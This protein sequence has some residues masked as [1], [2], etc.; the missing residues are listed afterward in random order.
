MYFSEK[1]SLRFPRVTIRLFER[2]SLSTEERGQGISDENGDYISVVISR[3]F[4][5]LSD[6][7]LYSGV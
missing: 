1:R 6:V 7:P 5:D 2:S 3:S 4:K